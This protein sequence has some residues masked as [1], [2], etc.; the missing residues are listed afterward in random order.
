MKRFFPLA[1]L[2]L[3]LLAGAACRAEKTSD[4]PAARGVTGSAETNR[5]VFR[6][7]DTLY[8][9]SDFDQYVRAEVGTEITRMESA[10]LSSLFDEFIDDHLLLE[11]A[12]KQ[13]ITISVEEKAEYLAKLG[14]GTLTEE[15]RDSFL[16]AQYGPLLD[17]LIIDKHIRLLTKDVTV[18]EEEIRD[19]YERNQREFHL[20]DRVEASQILLPTEQKAVEIWEKLRYASEEGFRDLARSESIGPEATQGG[21][22]GQFERGQLPAEMEAAIFALKEGE[23]SPV[24]ESSYGFHIFRLDRRFAAKTMSLAEASASIAD[25]IREV[26]ITTAVAR[27]LRELEGRLDWAVFPENLSFLYQRTER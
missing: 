24:V 3:A 9:E 27:H 23:I 21:A 22:M 5:V 8:H 20:T 1:V 12:K 17:K 15:E 11:E 14:E 16:T 6:V 10:T 19:Y 2:A 18:E 26:K 13:D 25:K 7:G 4:E